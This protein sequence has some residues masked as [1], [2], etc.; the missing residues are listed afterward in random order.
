MLSTLVITHGENLARST[1]TVNRGTV[2]HMTT[3]YALIK[4]EAGYAGDDDIEE[5]FDY[6][7]SREEAER[8]LDGLNGK[9][10]GQFQDGRVWL[11]RWS[12]G[13]FEIRK[14]AVR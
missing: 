1:V 4:V 10:C 14:I 2:L 13:G 5:V 7:T 6:F 12:V 8:T 11:G 9:P 3:I